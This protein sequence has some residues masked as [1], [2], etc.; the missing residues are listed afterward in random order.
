M[1]GVVTAFSRG[2][3]RC[4]DS[5][6]QVHLFQTLASKTGLLKC[7]K[8]EAKAFQAVKFGVAIWCN[9]GKG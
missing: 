1:N 5:G 2:L 4:C 3:Y 9:A 6:L 7:K 8:P